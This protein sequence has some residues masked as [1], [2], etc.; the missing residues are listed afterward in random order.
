MTLEQ[1]HL[2]AIVGDAQP[3][4]KPV[5]QNRD[6]RRERTKAGVPKL[7]ALYEHLGFTRA[8]GN[9]MAMTQDG[10]SRAMEGATRRFESGGAVL[11]GQT[12]C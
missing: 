9:N 6:F 7:V 11:A 5:R 1:Q 4:G 10:Y 2:A 3:N 8:K 12:T